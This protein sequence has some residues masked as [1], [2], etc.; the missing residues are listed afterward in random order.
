[1]L[2]F[3]EDFLKK[4]LKKRRGIEMTI[5]YSCNSNYVNQTMI[6]MLSVIQHHTEPIDFILISDNLS[7]FDKNRIKELV[8][9]SGNQTTDQ[10]SQTRNSV[11]YEP[12]LYSI[13]NQIRNQIGSQIKNQI[14]FLEIDTIP[15]LKEMKTDGVH[16]KSI[17]AKLFPERLTDADRLLYLDS[18]VIANGSFSELFRLDLQ[19]NSIA[20]VKMPYSISI[21]RRQGIKG[22]VFICDGMVL[23]DVKQW[24][25]KQ[26]S[27]KAKEYIDRYDGRP[28]RMSE[29][30]I[31]YVCAGRIFILPPKYHLM[32]QFLVFDNRELEK[33]YRVKKYYSWWEMEEARKRP[34]L[35]HFIRE[36]YNRPWCKRSKNP[37]WNHPY[38][39]LYVKYQRELGISQGER[40]SLSIRNK[41]TRYC[42]EKLPFSVFL[43]LFYVMHKD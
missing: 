18:D 42:Y 15:E 20:G 28:E 24:K 8:E 3:E 43:L 5:L 1:M 34:V 22:E 6:S 32:P 21:L 10:V 19:G 40:E 11:Q 25:R 29:S 27:K 2:S 23:I 38:R 14:R 13:K 12:F 36:L 39:G 33:M 37:M 7:D 26:L 17:Y 31:N 41:A 16:P 9:V 4:V 35:I 30:A